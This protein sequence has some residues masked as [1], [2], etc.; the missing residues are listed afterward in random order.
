VTPLEEEEEEKEE[1]EEP[2][3]LSLQATGGRAGSVHLTEKLCS[4][5]LL[6]P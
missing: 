5:Y 6:N 2:A 1:E 3:T 4:F